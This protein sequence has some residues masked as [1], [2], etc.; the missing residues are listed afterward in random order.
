MLSGYGPTNQANSQSASK[1]L[2]A[3]SRV[4]YHRTANKRK[5][6]QEDLGQKADYSV[7]YIIRIEKGQQNPA[8]DL[9]VSVAQVFGLS[10]SQLLA[11]A[12]RKY[13]RNRIHP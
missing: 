10:S 13:L 7:R 6:S 12:E 8:L 2:A 1:Y 3:G 9:L 11:K 4:S 5:W